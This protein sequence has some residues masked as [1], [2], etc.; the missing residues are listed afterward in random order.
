ML[1]IDAEEVGGRITA[2]GENTADN[3]FDSSLIAA[4]ADGSVLERLEDI[5]TNAG[6]L[7][8]AN[9]TDN[10]TP[11]DVVGNKEDIAVI[12]STT[13]S[14]VGMLKKIYDIVVNFLSSILILTETG[15]T[16]TTDG[17]EQDLYINNAPFGVF[18]PKTLLIDFANQTAAETVVITEYYRIKSGGD[19]I[20]LDNN[21][22]VAVQDPFLKSVTLHPNRFG[23]KVTIEK[24]G[25]AN[26]AYDYEVFYKI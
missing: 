11:S 1:H 26:Q 16:I 17:T 14:V 22:Y 9:S 13:S 12:P 21:T 24:T 25:G 15:G 10:L 8:A 3:V 19:W 5:S 7:P 23:I 4:N 18:D 6:S 20:K 2:V